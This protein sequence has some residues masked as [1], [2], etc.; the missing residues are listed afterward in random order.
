MGR[1]AISILTEA[2]EELCPDAGGGDGGDDDVVDD[3]GD[4]SAQIANEVAQ[5]K[6]K[7]KQPFDFMTM[8]VSALVYVQIKYKD[9]P[10][11]AQ[12]AAHVCR[13]IKSTQQKKSRLCSRF[14]PVDY[15]CAPTADAMKEMA[16]ESASR[17]F[18]QGAADDKKS[19]SVDV[20]KRAGSTKFNKMDVINVFAT[21]I[22][23]P[24]YKVNLNAPDRSV[25]VN[26]CKGSCG[27]SVGE[28]FRELSK[29]NLK[30]LV[31]EK[32]DEAEGEGN[33]GD[34]GGGGDGGDEKRAAASE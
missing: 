13:Q 24:P 18:S 2:Y 14:N 31:G 10:S 4:I 5:L 22:P 6:D 28:D 9:G 23:Q 21:I 3:G 16:T 11:A 19:F 8:G 17:Y 27:V 32:E 33:D 25:L 7:S 26:I 15:V 29:Y 12:L 34:G 20:E 30:A 1:E